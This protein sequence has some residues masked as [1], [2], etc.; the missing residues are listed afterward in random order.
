MLKYLELAN[1]RCGSIISTSQVRIKNWGTNW[2]SNLTK[3]TQLDRN[4]QFNP[5]STSP[6]SMLLTTVFQSHLCHRRNVITA[7]EIVES[8]LTSCF[9]I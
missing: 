3:I 4:R 2:L 6:V 7:F 5:D 9:H 1:L 8:H